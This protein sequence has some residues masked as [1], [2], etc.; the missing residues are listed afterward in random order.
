MWFHFKRLSI[1]IRIDISKLFERGSFWKNILDW[2]PKLAKV[3]YLETQGQGK[4]K[5]KTETYV[6]AFL[7]QTK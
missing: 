5:A 6:V 1:Q 2:G 7:K 3:N 4:A